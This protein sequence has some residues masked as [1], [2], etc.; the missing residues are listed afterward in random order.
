[1]TSP[2]REP[3]TL[4]GRAWIGGLKPHFKR[5]I[6]P[7]ILSIEDQAAAPALAALDDAEP[8]L[9]RIAALDPGAAWDQATRAE[10]VESATAARQKIDETRAV[11]GAGR[12]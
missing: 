6:V 11:L 3:R 7:T 5:G 2:D 8:V 4:A 12:E 9:A 10:L 1:V